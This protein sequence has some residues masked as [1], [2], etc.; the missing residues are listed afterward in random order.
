MSDLPCS[1]HL[2]ASVSCADTGN[3]ATLLSIQVKP[4]FS[5]RS[6]RMKWNSMPESGPPTSCIASP[7][8][9]GPRSI[10]TNPVLLINSITCCLASV[11]S[12]DVKMTVRGLFGEKS[13][14]QAIGMLL[15]DFTSRAPTA[16]SATISLDLRPFSA[17]RDLVTPARLMSAFAS[18]CALVASIRT[19]PCQSIPF[20]ASGTFTQLTARITTSHSAACSLVPA[21]AP[22]RDRRRNRLV[23]STPGI[24]YNYGVT[25]VYQVTAERACYVPGSQKTYFHNSPP[26][27]FATFIGVIE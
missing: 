18:M 27:V 15:R 6:R 2:T 14:I 7:M 13:W 5:H 10:A 8:A 9:S 20:N 26:A 22:D 19:R 1:Q 25:S 12:P 3:A 17:A 24:G 11:S 21:M 4:L 16:I 23:S